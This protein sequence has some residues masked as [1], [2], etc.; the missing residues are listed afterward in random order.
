MPETHN[1]SHIDEEDISSYLKDVR[2][3]YEARERSAKHND[4][5]EQVINLLDSFDRNQMD[6][7]RSQPHQH[8]PAST[9]APIQNVA[10]PNLH[11][12]HL[13]GMPVVNKGNGTLKS[14]AKVPSL[15]ATL[16]Y[17]DQPPFT[18]LETNNSS[19]RMHYD[20][21][22][23]PPRG[24]GMGGGPPP[25]NPSNIGY[26]PSRFTRPPPRGPPRW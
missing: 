7:N 22:L 12:G 6:G 26:S 5:N 24:S 14:E 23:M 15:M 4:L 11:R 2:Q 13:T 18:S 21:H 10:D 19:A 9:T 16:L 25:Y 17:P 3:A 1:L 20:P 8:A